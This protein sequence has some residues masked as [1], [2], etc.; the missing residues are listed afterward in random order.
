MKISDLI[1]ENHTDT[2]EERRL[3]E[4]YLEIALLKDA[5]DQDNFGILIG[6]RGMLS[7]NDIREIK[8]KLS[9][10]IRNNPLIDEGEVSRGRDGDEGFKLG[11]RKL[12]HRSELLALSAIS[13]GLAGLAVISTPTVV[14]TVI[15]GSAS[16]ATGLA[17][18]NQSNIIGSM[19]TLSRVLD[20]AD[21][22]GEL[23]PKEKPSKFR[24]I[25]NVLLRKK[26]DQ[27]EKE[28]IERIKKSSKKA[29]RKMEKSLKGI[30][31]FVE[32]KDRTGEIKRYPTSQLFNI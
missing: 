2:V 3:E 6:K 20:L 16:A 12:G 22:Y 5:F 31:K 29:Q 7:Y 23:S 9:S 8:R 4:A 15:A 21:N 28:A 26:P 14:G 1:E 11:L 24:R 30:S 32:Y 19:N 18:I 17:A 25:L 27:I 10:I 13:A